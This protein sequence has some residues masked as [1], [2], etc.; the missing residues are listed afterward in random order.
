MKIMKYIALATMLVASASAFGATTVKTSGDVSLN[1]DYVWRGIS[2]TN[3]GSA[4]QANLTVDI[5]K[6]YISAFT[7]NVDLPDARYELDLSA[8]FADSIGNWDYDVGAITYM[9]P[10]QLSD[11]SLDT[12]EVYGGGAYNFNNL[13]IGVKVSYSDDYF[14]SG[15]SWY[16]E[17]PLTITSRYV[18]GY[19]SVGY[20]NLNDSE[21]IANTTDYKIGAIGHITNTVD[22][23]L[24]YTS[25]SVARESFKIDF[26]DWEDG[27]WTGGLV[28]NF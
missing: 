13:G 27:D 1:S 6:F 18:D 5:N 28:Y 25:I 21:V 24:Q 20:L 22:V 10:G 14:D 15:K 7:S 2:Q 4:A 17:V 11:I 23:Y 9:Y 12:W 16:T 8:G 19:A 3:G 26:D